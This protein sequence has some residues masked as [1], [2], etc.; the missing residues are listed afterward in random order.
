[1]RKTTLI[2]AV[3]DEAPNSSTLTTYDEEHLLTY[4]RL[5]DAEADGAEWDEAALLVLQIDPVREPVR[6]YRVWEGHLARATWLAEHGYGHLL[7]DGVP[8]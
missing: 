5:L 7:Y 2:P 8:S 3:V 4:L 1:M 6:A